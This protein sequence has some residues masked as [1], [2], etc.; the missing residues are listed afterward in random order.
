MSKQEK[1]AIPKQIAPMLCKLVRA[2]PELENYLYEIKWDGYRAISYVKESM[3][4][5][6]SRGGLNYTAR[7]PQ[8]EKALRNLKHDVIIDGEIVVFNDEGK[9]DFDALQK[10]NGENTPISYCVFD[11]LWLDGQNLEQR[12]LTERKELLK[13]LVNKRAVFKFSKSFDDGQSL[14]KQMLSQNLEGVVA[15]R[16]DS[17]YREGE[18]GN[19]WLKI[20]T[21][22][23]QEFV[24]GGWAESSK[25]RP[26]KSLL[27][28]A[29]EN[30]R[31]TWI[32]RS[33]GGYKEKEMVDIL[34][35]LKAL[36]MKTSPFVNPVLDAKGA[37]VHYVRPRLV[38]N[39]EFAT[40]TK[41]GRIRKPATFLG[42]RND[43]RPAD[44]VREIPETLNAIK[45][46]VANAK[47][48]R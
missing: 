22:K 36:E 2:L 11:L 13:E 38:A 24:I 20:P 40:W 21:R 33:G 14:Y 47:T 35:K 34:E 7:Y 25:K 15:K 37:M 30:D 6:D 31:F 27:F 1:S 46:E 19:D 10:Y 42:F 12:P 17:P 26:F 28:G 41:T 32:G 8:I 3:V 44:V 45:N 23:R 16:K 4:H 18:R 29:Y 48:D 9:P 43:K 39:F 5:M